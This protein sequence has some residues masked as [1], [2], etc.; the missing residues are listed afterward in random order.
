MFNLL[1][2]KLVSYTLAFM[3]GIGIA[4]LI[5]W[6][7]A[8]WLWLTLICLGVYGLLNTVIDL[9]DNLK[10]IPFILLSL[11]ILFFGAARYRGT[12]S[13]LESDSIISYND[14]GKFYA[15]EG[16]I[17]RLPDRRDHYIQV[18]LEVKSITLEGLDFHKEVSGLVLVRLPI[19]GNWN[20]GDQVIVRGRLETPSV[21]EEFSYKDY[22]ARQGIYS[23]VGDGEAEF[24]ASGQG[25]WLLSGILSLK[26]KMLDLVY[27]FYPDPEASLVA[28]ILLGVESGIPENVEQAFRDTGTSHI[29][30][31]S[32]F[33][34]TIVVSLFFV[35]F[36]RWFGQNWGRSL[37]LLG[38]VVYVVLVGADAAVVRA[39]LMGGF[40]L[41]ARHVGRRQDGVNTLMGTAAIMVLW[42]PL[43][44]WDVGFQLSF[45]AVLGLI[46]YAEPF[47]NTF[48]KM[49][50][51]KL[52]EET[53]TKLIQ[54]VS[55]YFLFT[56]AAQLTTL[57]VIIYHFQRVSL[58]SFPAN[59]AILPAQPPIMILGGVGVLLGLL[60]PGLGQVI[61][62]LVWPFVAYTIR[63]VEWFAEFQGG[64]W[65]LGD[66]SGWLVAIFFIGLLAVTFWPKQ[67][68]S[69]LPSPKPGLIFASLFVLTMLVWRVG[70]NAPD[71]NLHITMLDVGTGDAFLIHTPEGRNVLVGGGPSASRLSDGLGRRLPLGAGLD[72]LV[73]ASPLEEQVAGLPPIIERFVPQEVL[74]AGAP[75]ASRGAVFLRENLTTVN[76]PITQ[77]EAGQMLDLG[78]GAVLQVFAVGEEGSVIMIQWNRFR[79]LLPIGVGKSE[80]T[81][82]GRQLGPVSVYLLAGNGRTSANPL[83]ELVAL[84]PQVILLGVDGGNFLGL[85]EQELLDNLTDYTLLR[86]DR[87]GWV[88]ISTDGVKMWAESER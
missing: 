4:S 51:R 23:L 58:T 41:L 83:E 5:P 56:L 86:T 80:L 45:A 13:S 21:S 36:S 1:Q 14:D 37:A 60:W 2:N 8:N 57:P 62:Y 6:P 55:E 73:V 7:T 46:L 3:C 39:A 59:I 76:I 54:P 32:G 53:V 61:S 48:V 24:V 84:N 9:P 35:W 81:G 69:H 75:N 50:S 79:M 68:L 16:V 65:V 17:D 52:S 44:L 28:G 29:I 18:H 87:N 70:L 27:Q 71:G 47:S 15:I 88:K 26:Q 82:L 42:N 11:F 77:A 25:G 74:W 38:I 31:I 67:V 40:G 30:A 22:L 64:V 85:P 34:I 63:L 43:V 10:Y 72:Y 49:A 78:Q 20:Y 19:E 33:N 66:I 12:V